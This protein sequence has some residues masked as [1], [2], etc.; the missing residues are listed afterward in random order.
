MIN[1]FL[2]AKTLWVLEWVLGS[3]GLKLVNTSFVSD[4]EYLILECCFDVSFSVKAQEKL[5]E[6]LY[7]ITL[8]SFTAWDLLWPTSRFERLKVWEKEKKVYVFFKFVS[9]EELGSE[10]REWGEIV[11]FPAVKG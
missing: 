5:K 2:S 6:R 1:D 11:R 9:S 3:V 4:G 8:A 7:M 10:E